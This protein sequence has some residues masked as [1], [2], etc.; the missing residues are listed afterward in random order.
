MKRTV[1]YYTMISLLVSGLSSCENWLDVN[2]KSEIKADKLYE[3]EAGFKDALIG[4]YIGMTHTDVYG[5]N[6][7][8]QTIEF[9]ACQYQNS[10]NSFVELQKCN[11][12]DNSS[13]KFINA[14][15]AKEYNIIAEANLLL[16]S[17]EKKGNILHPIIY[18][19]I[20]GEV[21]AIR[22]MCHFD[23]IRLFAKGNLKNNPST[24]SESC[25]PYVTE[26]GKAITP[27]KSYAETLALLHQDI[28]AALGYLKSDPLYPD[29]SARPEDY[30]QITGNTFFNGTYAKGRETRL[31]YPAVLLLKARV[32]LWEGNEQAALTNAKTLIA[33]YEQY[34]TENRKQWANTAADINSSEEANRDYVFKGEL[35]FALDVPKL[36]NSIKNAYPETVNGNT[37][38]DRLVQ[39]KEFVENLFNTSLASATDL[40]FRKQWEQVAGNV[41]L[42]IKARKTEGS[43]YYNYLPLMRISEAYLIAAECLETVDKEK[44]IDYLNYLKEKRNIQPA[45][46]LGYDI[47]SE[48]V[49]KEIIQDYR[50]EFSQEGQLFFCYKRLGLKTFAGKQYQDDMEDAQYKLPYPA[51]EN[52]LGQRN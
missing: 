39:S 9:M 4:L 18:N 5:A 35:L 31:S 44:S 10:N 13:K 16:E 30:N 23:L 26:Y 12:E 1:I 17:L 37:N 20:K 19:V 47:S 45:Y 14:T 52:D 27:Q 33:A 46:F 41:Y 22:A 43:L 38:N 34:V 28:D 40:R 3:T 8:W 11:Y 24:L 51:I 6:L 25:I 15:W 42:T 50:R 21:L 48:E 36:E 2:P 49:H 29:I 32:C 7:S